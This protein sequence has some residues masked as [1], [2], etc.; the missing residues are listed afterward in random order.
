MRFGRYQ[1]WRAWSIQTKPR[2][3]S[4]GETW[5]GA[6]DLGGTWAISIKEV[7][8]SPKACKVYKEKIKYRTK[9][10]RHS[11]KDKDR[12][13][14]E[15][16]KQV[17]VQEDGMVAEGGVERG[18]GWPCR[19]CSDEAPEESLSLTVGK[20]WATLVSSASAEWMIWADTGLQ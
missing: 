9:A 5:T 11:H 18:D 19:L 20:P 7:G 13:N 1:V 6:P 14:Q 15:D 16:W 17:T 12:W 10:N 4:S 8:D 2:R 3:W